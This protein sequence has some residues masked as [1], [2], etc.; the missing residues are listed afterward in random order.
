MTE[1]RLPL[2][3]TPGCTLGSFC[4]KLLSNPANSW[5]SATKVCDKS[6][7]REFGTSSN[8]PGE[9]ES[10][11]IWARSNSICSASSTPPSLCLG[12]QPLQPRQPLLQFRILGVAAFQFLLQLLVQSLNRGQRHPVRVDRAD[13]L[14]VGAQ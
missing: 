9:V 4:R 1:K 3:P 13:A 5:H 11:V 10:F 8:Y 6:W 7:R 12:E 2:S 14:V